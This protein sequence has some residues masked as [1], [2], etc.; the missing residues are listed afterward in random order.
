MIM[1]PV[2]GT[3]AEIFDSAFVNSTTCCSVETPTFP[4]LTNSVSIF[5][6]TG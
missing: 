4:E 2:A 1:V 6:P 3:V 5:C